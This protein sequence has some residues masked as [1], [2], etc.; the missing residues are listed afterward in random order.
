MRTPSAKPR[1]SLVL[2]FCATVTLGCGCGADDDDDVIDAGAEADAREADLAGACPL[3]DKVGVFEIA[4]R[5]MY[6][7]ITGQVADG[8][9]PVTVLQPEESAGD[10]QLW[11][12][13]NPFC[14]PAC[15]TGFVCNHSG[16]C[17]PYPAN[18]SAGTVTITGLV[19]PVSLE[20]NSATA[21]Q[22][23]DVSHPPFEAGAP[24]LLSAEGD[25]VAGFELDGVGVTVLSGIDK[26]W[27]V[28]AGEP[29]ALTWTPGL[30]HAR[31]LT[32]LNVDQHGNAPVTMYCDFEDTGAGSMPA[33]LIDALIAQGLSGAASGHVFRRTVDSV[34][35]APGACVELTVFSHVQTQPQ[36][37]TR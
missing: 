34:E 29:L 24:I 14:D 31:V 26:A 1:S 18:Q 20:P 5:E 9:V 4:H 35:I 13:V 8:V 16:A 30:G 23:T 11:R 21:Y 22:K 28:H 32:T 3:A 6:S 10:C 36:V 12:R 37:I 7:A 25:A 15:D 2:A 19:D 33:S 27:Q 17:V